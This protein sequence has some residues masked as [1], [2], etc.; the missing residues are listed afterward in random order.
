LS[1]QPGQT[2]SKLILPKFFA[3]EG[4]KEAGV[5][6]GFTASCG[7]PVSTC[8]SIKALV[9]MRRAHHPHCG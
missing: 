6:H 3:Q 2:A 5:M 8:I 9:N 7:K 4:E 1:W